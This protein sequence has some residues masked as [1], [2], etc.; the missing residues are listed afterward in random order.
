MIRLHSPRNKIKT[1][2]AKFP[3]FTS[4]LATAMF[5]RNKDMS[6][7]A[8]INATILADGKCPKRVRNRLNKLGLTLSHSS[9]K[10]YEKKFADEF[11]P[12]TQAVLTTA[13]K[14]GRKVQITF[15]N[16]DGEFHSRHKVPGKPATTEYHWVAETLHV[17]DFVAPSNLDRTVPQGDIL[18]TPLTTFLPNSEDEKSLYKTF[19]IIALRIL[20]RS[21]K[22]FEPMKTL[23]IDHIPHPFPEAAARES[24][25]VPLPIICKNENISSEMIQIQARK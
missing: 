5:A 8:A 6:A 1:G 9:W 13:L 4:T 12:L 16:I 19:S 14:E 24:L 21:L 3:Q 22:A 10:N 23:V 20:V 2:E 17:S 15:D 7:F 25:Q 11:V 18:N